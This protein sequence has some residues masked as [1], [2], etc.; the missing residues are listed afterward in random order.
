MLP[1]GLPAQLPDKAL[2]GLEK[3]K[4]NT[5]QHKAVLDCVSAM[6]QDECWV[7]L[8][9]GPPGTGKTK[10]IVSLLWSMLMKGRRT[11][12]CAPTNTAVVEVASRLL[13][14]LE[15]DFYG[16][17]GRH[18]SLGD[19]V[20]Y[21]NEDRMN[22]D[23]NL[24]KIFSEQRVSRLQGS[25]WRH[26]INH[27]LELLENPLARHSSYLRDV[28]SERTGDILR[29]Q[30][31]GDA[32]LQ[33][34][35]KMTFKDFFLDNY[36]SREEALRDCLEALR[37]DLPRGPYTFVLGKTLHS[38][39]AF[40]KLLRSEPERPLR[41]LFFKNAGWPE[42]QEARALCLDKLARLTDSL[43]LP[44][45][46]DKIEEFILN[47]ASI[48]LCTACSSFNLRRV[49]KARP[50]SLLVVDEAA[51]LKECESLIP[52]QLG[53]RRAVLIGDECQL[54]ALVKSKVISLISSWT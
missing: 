48:I 33:R 8:I 32:E 22:V 11:L 24:S 36:E 28:R 42:F 29:Q 40:G 13:G 10:A 5:S 52:L 2:D 3:F 53:I 34:R 12:A 47:H 46:T 17:D 14:L 30:G 25:N 23:K 26:R 15:D 50:F 20:L 54:P 43:D 1:A 7:R 45:T 9:W 44:Y 51:Q 6:N 31:V 19:V 27:M 16:G 18:F 21:G 37:R 38:L 4:L 49:R 41:K 39:E 35:R